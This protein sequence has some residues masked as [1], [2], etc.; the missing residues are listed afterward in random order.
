MVEVWADPGAFEVR[1]GATVFNFQDQAV[2]KAAV[3]ITGSTGG[4]I[5]HRTPQGTTNEPFDVTVQLIVSG[6]SSEV[7]AS[8]A[9][10][11]NATAPETT[12]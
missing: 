11:P 4:T 2:G 8:A 5:L 1:L 3:Q 6:G 10:E 7:I 9:P 12:P